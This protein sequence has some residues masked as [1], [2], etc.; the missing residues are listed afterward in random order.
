MVSLPPV[1][2]RG[3][4]RSLAANTARADPRTPSPCQSVVRAAW[5][6]R[7]GHRARLGGRGLSC[8]C[9]IDRTG[10]SP[11]PAKPGR[12][13][14]P[15]TLDGGSPEVM[16]GHASA[17]SRAVCLGCGVL[18]RAPLERDRALAPGDTRST[19]STRSHGK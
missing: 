15:V 4:A 7:R 12:F 16:A 3:L 1:V 19:P 9:T 6:L 10:R 17:D 13:Q 2:C 14:Y 5:Y 8:C 18:W 11:C